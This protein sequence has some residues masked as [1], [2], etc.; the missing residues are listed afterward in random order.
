MSFWAL[1][2]YF[3]ALC[4]L[5]CISCGG[6]SSLSES[7]TTE[8]DGT[9]TTAD[10]A[11][12]GNVASLTTTS[13]GAEIDLSDVA[14]D[15]EIVVMLYSFSTTATSN[16]FEMAGSASESAQITSML[17][18]DETDQT[19]SQADGDLTEE[20]HLR[21]RALEENLDPNAALTN[22]EAGA[23]RSLVRYS[24][25][26]TTRTFK[27]LNS[28]SNSSSYD[29]V[30]AELRYA[31]DYFEFYVDE[32][33]DAAL[34]DTDLEAIADQ[35]AATIPLERSMFGDESDVNGDDKFAVLFT[36][37]VNELGGSSGGM[38]TGFFYAVDLFDSTSYPVSNEM[39][40]YYTFVPDPSGD[41]GSAVTKSFALS[42]IYPGVLPHEYQHMI[43]FNM[44][45]NVNGGSAEVGW[46]NEGLS[47]LAEDIHS[48]TDADFMEFTGD[49]NPAR[50]ETYLESI[51]SICF[52]CGTSLSQRGGSYLF[53]RYLYEQ[54]QLGNLPNV[55]TGFALLNNLLDTDLRSDDNII[56]AAFGDAG[57]DADLVSTMGLFG[58]AV[59]LDDTDT[60]T[61]DRL[62]FTGIDLRTTQDDNRG[63]VL[64]GP[65][66]QSVTS[67]PFTDTLTGA[68]LT[69]L[70][71]TGETLQNSGGVLSFT[72]ADTTTV[73]GYVIRE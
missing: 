34:D 6:A 7:D 9:S 65:A 43:S 54:A 67:L 56:N 3:S 23:S 16:A 52:T 64:S 69:Y 15:E 18:D 11:V 42:N 40:I 70:R 10:A 21:L 61:D 38:V 35:F 39:E 45:Y 27:V 22:G 72:F 5:L 41:Y 49:E 73:G 26:G 19:E 36:Q 29:T 24:T 44:H 1:R 25:L 71:M 2:F 17:H 12:G 37:S 50:V 46:L 14:T 66:I 57:T 51:D 48:A 60:N 31:N 59:Y 13:S 33:N 8:T 20:F 63:T 53:V 47:H 4:I 55:T 30:T 28:F 68:T 62:G 32:R 58:L